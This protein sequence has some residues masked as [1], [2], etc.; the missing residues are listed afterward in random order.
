MMTSSPVVEQRHEQVEQR[1]LGA[2][3]DDDVL[4]GV[5]AMPVRARSSSAATALR[6]SGVPET[7]GVLADALLDAPAIAASLMCSGVSKSGSP[8][9]KRNHVDALGLQLGRLGA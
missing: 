3:G 7:G 8:T 1:V 9:P 4:G 5:Y 6:S 2:D